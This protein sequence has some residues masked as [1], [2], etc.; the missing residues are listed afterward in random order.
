[1]EKE[2]SDEFLLVE[3][4]ALQDR[5]TDIEKG[6]SGRLNFLLIFAGAIVAGLGQLFSTSL[7]TQY[8]ELAAFICCAI[9]LL[10]GFF[11]LEHSILDSITIVMMYRR[12]GRIRLWFV[13]KCPEIGKYVP[14]QFG[15]DRP[16]MDSPFLS[17]RGGEAIIFTINMIAFCGIISILVRP[18]TMLIALLMMLVTCVIAWLGQAFYVHFRLKKAEEMAEGSVKFRYAKMYEK[19][20]K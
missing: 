3:F 5:A 11:T 12:M 19:L 13:N 15:D 10:L 7:L 17:L 4:N 2:L 6:K 20:M 8:I 9:L 1:M 14:F 16:R 18:P